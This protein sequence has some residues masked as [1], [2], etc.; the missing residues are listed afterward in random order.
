MNGGIVSDGL[1]VTHVFGLDQVLCLTRPGNGGADH[2]E[3]TPAVLT[4]PRGGCP[5]EPRLMLFGDHDSSGAARLG[6][7][8]FSDSHF[9][10]SC[11]DRADDGR[12]ELADVL[13]GGGYRVSFGTRD[14][15]R[16]RLDRYPG[17]SVALVRR[18]G[19]HV[20]VVR[21][22]A[23]VVTRNSPGADEMWTSICGSFLYCWWV[24]GLSLAELQRAALI[25][26]RFTVPNAGR[27]G[28]L[29]T[30]GRVQVTAVPA[31]SATRRLA[32]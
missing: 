25:V 21:D 19:G 18:R 14:R 32:S 8:L 12:R 23:T 30:M 13:T 22:G 16:R 27:P 7:L 5:H 9:V 31:R 17:C 26:G 10:A 29:E 20:A 28:S 24:A 6:S 3:G 4:I 11:D 1:V 2:A 15:L